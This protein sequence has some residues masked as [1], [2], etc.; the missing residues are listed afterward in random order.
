M[1]RIEAMYSQS[2]EWLTI[3]TAFMSGAMDA[4]EP[5]ST[6]IM[7]A[8]PAEPE[9]ALE[10]QSVINLDE[11]KGWQRTITTSGHFTILA[12]TL[13]EAPDRF[14]L[15]DWHLKLEGLPRIY[16][17]LQMPTLAAIFG[18]DSVNIINEVYAETRPYHESVGDLLASYRSQ[19]KQDFA[20]V[21]RLVAQAPTIVRDT[22]QNLNEATYEG[23]KAFV[24]RARCPDEIYCGRLVISKEAIIGL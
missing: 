17:R 5:D 2:G 8:M 22:A 11:T 13:P 20:S 21:Q 7:T 16:N 1:T 23:R 3:S 12:P 9:P 24:D 10:G 18:E 14:P 15:R 6:D 4:I 19:G